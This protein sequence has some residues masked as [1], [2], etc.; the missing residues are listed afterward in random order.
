M[1][2]FFDELVYSEDDIITFSSG[3]PGFESIKKYVMVKSDDFEPF[4]WLSAADGTKIRFAIINPMLFKPDY[5]PDIK[6]WQLEELA[7]ENK[8]DILLF[9]LVTINEDPAKST[10]NLVGPI[11]INKAKKVGKQ[12][13]LEDDTYSTREP[14]L[15]EN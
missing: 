6:K 9:T 8:E 2:D 11:I 15:G 7:I 14:I 12:V 5:S 3:I 10:V 1:A 4:Q 13:I